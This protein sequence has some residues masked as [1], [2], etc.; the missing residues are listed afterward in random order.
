MHTLKLDHLGRMIAMR[1]DGQGLQD[2]LVGVT[3]MTP[4]YPFPVLDDLTLF[5]A[6]IT[7][8]PVGIKA[9]EWAK[10]I[11]PDLAQNPQIKK[12]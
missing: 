12:Q 7:Q 8:A 9:V 3:K 1:E 10:T 2:N 4:N 6:T 5:P 11:K